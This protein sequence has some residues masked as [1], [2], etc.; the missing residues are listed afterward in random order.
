VIYEAHVRGLTLQHPDVPPRYRG[1]YA[2]LATAP[3][4]EHLQR[5]G[6]TAL[7]L[8]PTHAFVHDRHLVERRLKNY[9]GYNSIGYF[10]PATQYAASEHPERE[11]KTMVKALHSAGIEVILDVVYN[12]TAE[13]SHLGPTLSFRGIDNASYYRL[14]PND[15]RY[16]MDYTGCG[17]TLNMRHPRVLQLIMDSLRYWILEMHVDGF[18]FDLASALARELHAVDRLGAFFD[19]IRQD[20]VISQVKLIAEPWDLGEGGY[21]VGGF[22]AGWAEWNGRYRDAARAYWKGDGGLIGEMGYRLTGSSDLYGHSGRRPHASINFVTSHDGFTLAD[23]VTYEHKHNEANL[24]NNQ[25]GD[26]HNLSWNCGVE[27]PSADP[28]IRALR[29]RQQRNLLATLFLSQG[30]PMIPAGDEFGRT[31]QGNNNAYCQDN[32]ISWLDWGLDDAR[33]ELLDFV[34]RIVALRRAHPTF[35]RQ[36]F[37]EGRAIHGTGLRDIVWYDPSGAEMSDE[38]W[39][40]HHARCL[41]MYFDGAAIAEQDRRGRQVRDSDFLVMLNASASALQFRLPLPH[42]QARWSLVVDTARVPQFA[43]REGERLGST[44]YPLEARSVVVLESPPRES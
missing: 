11:F 37:F 15:G 26:N 5:L 23:L 22:P 17:N 19:I 24:E 38:Q 30:V 33:K 13:G 40:A 7:E 14:V 8:M 6:V 10:A 35:R 29:A 18:R 3:V 28:G 2:A 12:H 39:R 31:Q 41:G 44:R 20:P 4:I 27:G 25:D 1:T 36:H 42:P 32:E 43:S 21:Q 9:W 34:R 16:Y